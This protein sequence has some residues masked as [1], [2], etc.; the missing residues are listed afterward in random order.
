MVQHLITAGIVVA[1]LAL[2][3]ALGSIAV[4]RKQHS[5]EQRNLA[6]ISCIESRICNQNSGTPGAKVVK[7]LQDAPIHYCGVEENDGQRI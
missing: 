1:F 2:V 7:A 3:G 6:D 5:A 4:R